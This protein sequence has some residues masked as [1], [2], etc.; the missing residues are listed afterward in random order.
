[1]QRAAERDVLRDVEGARGADGA[2][3]HVAVGQH[4]LRPDGPPGRPPGGGARRGDRRH[5][6][7]AAHPP[8]RVRA[9][10]TGGHPPRDGGR[11]QH[12]R[13]WRRPP[14]RPSPSCASSGAAKSSGR[15]SAAASA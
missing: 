15:S 5:P 6:R 8:V 2:A 12:L 7:R 11:V 4:R 3:G 13:R 10:L 9:R 14:S 1:V